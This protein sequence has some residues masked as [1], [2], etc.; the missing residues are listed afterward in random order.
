[1]SAAPFSGENAC[2]TARKHYTFNRHLM[3]PWFEGVVLG[4]GPGPAFF[5]TERLA[6]AAERACE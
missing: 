2:I 3:M 5:I 6:D 4:V 1:M